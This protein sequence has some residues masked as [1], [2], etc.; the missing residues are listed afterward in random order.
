MGPAGVSRL[1][2]RV[3]EV[4]ARTL[5]RGFFRMVEHQLR[6]ER[7]DGSMS[8]TITR[9]IF[10]RGHAVAVLPYDPVSDTVVMIRQF[11]PGFHYAGENAWPLQIIAGMIEDGEREEDVARREAAEEA[12]IV[13]T[14]VRRIA[15]YLPSPGGSTETLTIFYAMID[16]SSAGGIAGLAEEHEDIRVEVIAALDAIAMLDAGAVMPST[17][18]IALHWLARNRDALRAAA[19]LR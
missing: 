3:D 13:V 15:K 2:A 5:Y 16:A 17:A 12:N 14:E 9:E 18:V 8:D 11:L 10:E 4:S 7:F 6:F 1:P 19:G